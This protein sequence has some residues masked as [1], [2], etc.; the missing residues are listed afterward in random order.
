MRNSSLVERQGIDNNRASNTVPKL[1]Q[2]LYWVGEHSIGG[3][4]VLS[5]IVERI[6]KQM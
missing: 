6:E 2:Y 4:A 5:G 1:S 3:E